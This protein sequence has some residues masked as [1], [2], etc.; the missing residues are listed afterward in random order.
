[1]VEYHW[2]IGRVS[3]LSN[4]RVKREGM[5]LSS[6]EDNIGGAILSLLQSSSWQIA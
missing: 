1:M 2:S 3:G 6:A 4:L 5:K